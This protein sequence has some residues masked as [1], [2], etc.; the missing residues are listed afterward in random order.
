MEWIAGVVETVANALH[1]PPA[2]VGLAV[3]AALVF[4]LLPAARAL[5]ASRTGGTA[6]AL[7]VLAL[8]LLP[9]ALMLA[10]T[11]TGSR[12][13]LH[14]RW[15]YLHARVLDRL[16][17]SIVL[18]GLTT[19]LAAAV[20]VPMAF[21]LHR[22]EFRGR[23][24]L[25]FLYVLPLLIPPHMHCIAWMRILGNQGFVTAWLLERGIELDVRTGYWEVGG[26]KTIYPGAAWV[27]ASSFWPFVTLLASAGFAHVHA[28]AEEAAILARGRRAALRSVTLPLVRAHVLAG[29]F[30]VFLFAVTCYPVPVLLNTP[31]IMLEIWFPSSNVDAKTAA[32]V[33]L[34][35]VLATV[36]ALALLIAW[37]GRRILT[38]ADLAGAVRPARRRSVRAGIAA[39]GIFLFM[40]GWPAA[41]LVHKAGPPSSYRALW[42]TN[43]PENV[44]NSFVL[45]A[46]G[47]V[48]IAFGATAVGLWMQRSSRRTQW[49]VE[50]GTL[51][52]FA[53]PAVIVGVA[54]NLFWSRFQSVSWID[55]AIYNGPGIVLLAYLAL[56]LPFGLRAVRAAL[57][58]IPRGAADAAS[59]AG[60]TPSRIAA[61]ITLPMA[62]AGIVAAAVLGF[63]LTLGELAA[64]IIV[65]PGRWQNAQVRIF[66]MIHFA[67]DE[68]VAALCVIMACLALLPLALYSL[69]FNRKMEVL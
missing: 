36:A 55:E 22:S 61:R 11:L 15:S 60:A 65:S 56:F 48:V 59:V 14:E 29:L 69:A 16:V 42:L 33:A 49:W 20:G 9:L 37:Q 30:L 64:G 51:M 3:A 4:A 67:R 31:T 13:E 53:F 17:N 7:L 19:V 21:L 18:A 35:L 26:E 62:R 32:V 40:A 54:M 41:C 52:T 44:R 1:V 45:A 10:Q 5:L 6:A 38:P 63:V 68:E 25:G 27:M 58:R 34:P 47:A 39:W 28:R 46:S 8:V 50:V 12:A 24:V 43:V 2:L 66:N 23:R 57:A